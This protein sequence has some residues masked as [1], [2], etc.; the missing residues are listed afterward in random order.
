MTCPSPGARLPC[1]PRGLAAAIALTLLPLPVL[2]LADELPP[3][4]SPKVLD[5]VQVTA[6]TDGSTESTRAYTTDAMATATGMM[7]SVRQTPQSVSVVTR[8]QMDDRGLQTTADA[9][10]TAP[11]ISVT[12]SDANRYSFSARGFDI[13]N[14][15]FDGVATPVLS[16]WNFGENNLDMVVFDRIEIVR[17]ATGLMT[18]AGNPSA[19]VNYVRKRPT[20]DFSASGGISLGSWDFRKAYADVSSPLSASGA[21]RGRLVVAQ[22]EGDSYTSGL[23]TTARTVYGVVSADISEDTGLIA[24]VSHQGNDNRGFGSGFALFHSDGSRTHFDRSVSA[25]APWARMKTDTTTGFIDLNHRFGN[26]WQVRLSYSQSHTDMA[27]KHLYRGGYPDRETGAMPSGNSFTR[28][29]GP[30][31]RNAYTVTVSGPFAL[32]GREHS[33]SLGWMASHDEVA[34]GQYRAL[35]PLPAPASFFDWHGPGTAEP[36]WASTTTQADDLDQRQS[37]AFAVARLS[38]AD[39][40]H[41]IVGAR[42]GNWKTDQTYF[43]A[44]RQ[45]RHR[46]QFV[47]YAGLVWDLGDAFS[48][49]ASYTSVFRPQNNRNEAGVILDPVTGD[50]YELG[51][52]GSWLQERLNG[53]VAVFRTT[54]DNLA[55]ATGNLVEGSTQPAYR[56]VRGATVQ[57]LELELAGELA[58]GWNLGGSYTTFVAQDA[59]GHAINTAKP[60]NLFKLFTT[61]RLPG[62]WNRLTL[63][64]GVDWQNRMYQLA[65]APGNRRVQ[66]EQPGYALVNLMARY[67]FTP[68]LS[69]AVNLNNVFDRVYYSQIGFYNQG[70]YGAPRNVMF[71]LQ[72]RY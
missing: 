41:A 68:R 38:L 44:V 34:L 17:G 67:A 23:G 36:T 33:A 37:G 42:L 2:A 60:R 6:D 72:M 51:I 27:M 13:S 18:G 25:T 52:K 56:A 64:G 29:D 5:T 21:V 59:Q 57:G 62:S 20:R 58:D 7:L 45:Y 66:V 15:Q 9:L 46:N 4:L 71:S 11:G 1:R 28:Y 16:P 3:P 8:Q 63:G 24:G 47:P 35:A 70:W 43:G 19:A 12:R 69:A 65:T 40:V 54:Q 30:V 53:S 55:E 22:A 61:W 14:F 48:A 26:Q 50:S 31:R 39:P 32:F 49:Y 10:S